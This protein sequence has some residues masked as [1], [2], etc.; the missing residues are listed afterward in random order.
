M[1]FSKRQLRWANSP[2]GRAALGNDKVSE[3]D[4]EAKGADLPERSKGAHESDLSAM[5]KPLRV[6]NG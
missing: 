6:K 4:A 1:P 5:R 3:W 2:T